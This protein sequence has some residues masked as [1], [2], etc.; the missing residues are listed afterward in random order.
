MA[1]FWFEIATIIGNPELILWIPIQ[2]ENDEDE[3]VDASFGQFPR[4][5]YY[6]AS[7]PEIFSGASRDLVDLCMQRSSGIHSY[8]VFASNACVMVNDNKW[9]IFFDTKISD[10]PTP[11]VDVKKISDGR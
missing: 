8:F 4:P 2:V 6:D 9:G 7:T 10:S 5:Y 3:M 1:R 11:D